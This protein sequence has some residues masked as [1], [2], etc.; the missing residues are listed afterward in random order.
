MT[1]FVVA[2]RICR[3]RG[4]SAF[5]DLRAGSPRV[6]TTD[7]Y[8]VYPHL[9]P[10]KRPLR[11]AHLRRDFRAMIDR[12]GSGAATGGALLACSDALFEH[13]YRARDGTRARSTLR[14]RY[15][16]ALRRQVGAF[17]RAGA[18]CGGPKTAAT[19]GERLPAEASLWTF[20]RVVG[21]EPTNDAA[22]RE[23]RHAVCGRK[24]RFGT[25]SGRGSRFVERVLTV[26]GSCRRQNRS[27]L[28]FLI[29]AVA[30]HRT[31][32]N[33]PSLVPA[34]SQQRR[35]INPLLAHC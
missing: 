5:D 12:G 19:C 25:D 2:F 20:A 11:G 30:A 8:P 26:I 21:A 15:A 7:R 1:T 32:E 17:R 13:W 22:E 16:P 6:H 4:R 29:D 18:A 3:T 34:E 28:T 14:T 31:G 9:S 10:H 23:A 24:T 35:M 27:V 33:A